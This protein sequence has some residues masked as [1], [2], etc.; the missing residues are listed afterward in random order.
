LE[1]IKAYFKVGNIYKYGG[2]FVQ[3]KVSSLED[4]AVIIAHF[5][6]YMLLTQ[7]RA[8]F[9]LFKRVVDR[10]VLNRQEHLTLDGLKKL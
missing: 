7:K 4:L 3:Y 2:T 8:D 1:R 10:L 9:E 5:D 6:K